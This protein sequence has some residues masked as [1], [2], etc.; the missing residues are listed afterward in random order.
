MTFILSTV[1]LCDLAATKPVILMLMIAS[2][3]CAVLAVFLSLLAEVSVII[4]I[5][6]F[7]VGIFFAFKYAMYNRTREHEEEHKRSKK[8]HKH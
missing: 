5:P 3:A 4:A 1:T 6:G 7:V 8:G 2:L